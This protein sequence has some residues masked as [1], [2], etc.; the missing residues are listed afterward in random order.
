MSTTK[1]CQ[2]CLAPWGRTEEITGRCRR[3]R[4]TTYISYEAN[5]G[6]EKIFRGP[7]LCGLLGI[8]Y[9]QLDY[10][11]RTD[12]LRPSLAEARGSGTK[13]MYSE[14]DMHKGKVLKAALDSG[15]SLQRIRKA[16]LDIPDL[17]TTGIL[18]IGEHKAW[19]FKEYDDLIELLE[20]NPRAVWILPLAYQDSDAEF[21]EA[22]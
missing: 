10:W 9:R 13:R 4:N 20:V 19:A 16:F 22:L 5:P 21:K 17:P 3:C 7:E 6:E 2:N 1:V 8:T 11:A 12:L 14:K 18:V 15:V